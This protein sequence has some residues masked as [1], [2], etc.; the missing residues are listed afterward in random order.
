MRTIGGI[1]EQRAAENPDREIVRFR[2][3][4]LTYRELDDRASRI[5]N[6]FAGLGL[7]RGDKVAVLLPNGPEFLASWFGITRAGMIEVPLNVGLRGD[8]L[9]YGLNQA[10]C[11][12]IIVN[13]EWV[14][15][16]DA[17]APALETLRH[18]IVVG[19]RTTSIAMPFGELLTAPAARPS[20]RVAPEDTAVLLFTSGTTGPSKAVVLSHNANFGLASSTISVMEYG[21]DEVFFT[22]FPLYHINAKYTTVLPAM[23][24]DHAS[25][26]VHDRFSVSGFWDTCRAEGVTAMN[27]MGALLLMLSKQPEREDDADNPVQKGF[28]APAP[29]A[30]APS[31]EER[32]GV[33]LLE[34]YGSTEVG[35]VIANRPANRRFGTCGRPVPAF[36]VEIHDDEG[37]PLPP[38]TPGEIVVKPRRPHTIIEEYYRMP[39]ATAAAFRDGWF[40]TGDRGVCDADGWFTFLDRTKDAI[41]RRGENISSWEVEQVLNDHPAIEETAVIGV[42]SVLTEEE[43]LAVVKVRDGVDLPPEAILDHAQERLPHFAVPRYVR[44]VSELPKNP[45]QRIQKFLL[46]DAGVTPDTWDREAVGY[47][48]TR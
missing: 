34:V 27:F 1:L 33:V 18:V 13:D 8:L 25:A 23:M 7:K 17:V 15:R 29:P 37:R 3:G 10:Q 21:E 20:I 14:G 44:F 46:R 47:V 40:R 48:V 19:N 12:A 16:V 11:R 36:E 32:F 35:T 43:V 9:A 5:A 2:H 24:L 26:V 42:P 45:Q 39:E 41:R 38:G 28:G 6:A 4:A 22:A 31:F 30:I